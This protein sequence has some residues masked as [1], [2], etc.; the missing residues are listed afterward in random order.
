MN[1]APATTSEIN[2]EKCA[3][4]DCTNA[5]GNLSC[6]NCVKLGIITSKFCGQDCFRR[7]WAEHKKIHVKAQQEQAGPVIVNGVESM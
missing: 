4:L 2:A 7:N 3:G 1:E 5:A 6:P